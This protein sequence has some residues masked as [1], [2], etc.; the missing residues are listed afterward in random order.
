M[1]E[2]EDPEGLTNVW[3]WMAARP[4]DGIL[5]VELPRTAKRSARSAKLEVRYAKVV[6]RPPKRKPGLGSVTVWVVT[7]VEVGAPPGQ[8]PVERKLITTVEVDTLAQALEVIA[9]PGHRH[10][11]GLADRAPDQVG[12]PSCRKCRARSFSKKPSGRHWWPSRP[13]TREFPISRPR[14]GRPSG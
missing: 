2:E 9:L 4:L 13:G 11:G 8:E 10:G 1:Q 7:A 3:Q 5:E 6:L 12:A 14:C